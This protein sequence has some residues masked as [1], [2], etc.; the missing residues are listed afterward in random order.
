MAS[1]STTYTLFCRRFRARVRTTGVEN[2]RTNIGAKNHGLNR[3]SLV[4]SSLALRRHSSTSTAALSTSTAAL[5][6]STAALS[7]STAALSMS[8]NGASPYT[9]RKTQAGQAHLRSSKKS[10]FRFLFSKTVDVRGAYSHCSTDPLEAIVP[11][12]LLRH[13]TCK[14]GHTILAV[15]PSLLPC[16]SASCSAHPCCP[17]SFP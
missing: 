6:T 13:A 10:S 17:M 7:T 8:A 5:S 3:I 15:P 1:S 12:R 14:G 16:Q 4:G 2:H 11:Y 9:K